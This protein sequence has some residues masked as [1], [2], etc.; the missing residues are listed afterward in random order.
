MKQAREVVAY[1]NWFR[2]QVEQALQEADD[3]NT[4]WIPHEVVKAD[5]QRQRE[6]LLE[7]AGQ[8]K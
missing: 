4:V 5:M 3:P 1:D 7:R 2:E 6:A 8:T